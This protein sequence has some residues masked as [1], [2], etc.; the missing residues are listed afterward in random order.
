MDG[1]N[2]HKTKTRR[3]LLVSCVKLKETLTY[4]VVSHVSHRCCQC[5][6][7]HDSLSA[8]TVS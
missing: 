2:K 8:T 7:S 1:S 4:F 3:L 5:C 6:E